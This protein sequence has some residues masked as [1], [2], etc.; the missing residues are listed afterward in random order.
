MKELHEAVFE[1]LNTGLLT[2]LVS[3]FN[4]N[5]DQKPP[6][7]EYWTGEGS[8][9]E[10]AGFGE[11]GREYNIY[12]QVTA[13]TAAEASDLYA[14]GELR[15]KYQRITLQGWN[16]RGKIEWV[17][18]LDDPGDVMQDDHIIFYEGACFHIEITRPRTDI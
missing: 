3:Y 13:R 16:H 4:A 15:L 11:E 2:G 10:A 18:A 12:I 6:Y 8:K 1:R 5:I 9:S 17:H 7:L 14:L